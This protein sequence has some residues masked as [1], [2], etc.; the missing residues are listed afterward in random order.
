MRVDL[1]PLAG[2]IVALGLCAA[3]GCGGE[4][5]GTGSAVLTDADLAARQA[6][7]AGLSTVINDA[8]MKF[9]PLSYEYDEDLLASIDKVEAR[10]SARE[11]TPATAP[12][13]LPKLDAAEEEAHFREVIRRWTAKTGKSLRDEIDRLKADVAASK[14]D[15]SPVRREFHKA[16]SAVFDDFIKLDVEEMRERRNRAIHEA[17]APLLAK[18]REAQPALVRETEATLDAPPYNLSQSPDPAAPPSEEVRPKS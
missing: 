1:R 6:I 2:L 7:T 18:Y 5:P 10:L 3:W 4:R 9:T 8:S 14:S 16:F 12:R 13:L 15:R 11:I 17:A